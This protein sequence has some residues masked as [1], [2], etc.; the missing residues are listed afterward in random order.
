[1]SEFYHQHLFA[2]TMDV[3]EYLSFIMPPLLTGAFIAYINFKFSVKSWKFLTQAIVLGFFS[4]VLVIAANYII[5]IWGLENLK[6]MR[7]TA[8]YVFVVVASGSEFAKF[9]VLQYKF[10]NLK[11]FDS[12]LAGIVYSIFISLGFSFSAVILYS[13]GILGAEK[14]KFITMFLWTYPLANIVFGIVLGFFSGMGKV[15]KN[16]FIDSTTGLGTAIFFHALYYFCFL[17]SDHRLLIFTAIGFILIS[18]TLL[19][20]AASTEPAQR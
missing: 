18:I 8:F 9:F 10:Y 4:V 14:M 6:N 13:F 3:M 1:M 16:R 12:P 2:Q 15:R 7:R 19:I 11:S 20:K 17:T 5:R